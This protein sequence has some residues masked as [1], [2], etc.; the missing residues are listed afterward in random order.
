M[1]DVGI[2]AIGTALPPYRLS[3]DK[4][5]ELISSGF[6]L[7]PLEK[8]RF[9]AISRACGIQFRSTVLSD[10]IKG[11]GQFD[12][13]PNEP[14]AP[15]PGT[16][17]RMRL[18][19]QHALPLAVAAI[20][21]SFA[22]LPELD[23]TEITHLITVSC[24]GMYAPGI[25]IEL[26]QHLKLSSST[27]RTA[28]NFM[29]CYGAFNGI[30]LAESICR[31]DLKAK[32]LVV[33][34]ELC[35]LH[36]QKKK[37]LDNLLSN[38]IFADG[39]A[40]VLIQAGPFLGKPYLSLRNF[41]CDILPQTSSEMAWEIADSGFDI[42]LSAYVPQSI[43]SGIAAFTKRLLSQSNMERKE[44]DFFAIHPG[45]G[46]ILKACEDAL[47]ISKE[48]NQYAYQVLRDH[49]NMSSATILFVLQALWSKLTPDA[50]QKNIFCCAFG[51]GLTLESMVLSAQFPEGV[52]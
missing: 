51:P 52:V 41:Y 35:T 18:Y 3:Q 30:K 33:C 47:K 13:F 4:I 10:I 20:E 1:Q 2:L 25:D 12:F 44:L 26:V 21:N 8:R 6:H 11:P 27:K 19:K 5:S 42:V 28:I 43:H 22:K 34:V 37:S 46:K 17:A 48:E 50:H 7:G 16:A 9:K 15:F 38:A 29:G 49:G 39:A 23:K 32:V 14:H 24:T 31:A 40:A 45:G 36:F